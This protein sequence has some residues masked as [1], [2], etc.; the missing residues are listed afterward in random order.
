LVATALKEQRGGRLWSVEG[1]EGLN[2]A[3]SVRFI[4]G[5]SSI[6]THN[7]VHRIIFYKLTAD[8]RPEPSVEL[9]VP[10]IR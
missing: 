5:I 1:V 9:V 8:Q 3:E 4:D 10:T 7:R 2:C 6:A